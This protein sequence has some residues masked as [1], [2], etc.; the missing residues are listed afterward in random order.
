VA[1]SRHDMYIAVVL[2]AL[3]CQLTLAPHSAHAHEDDAGGLC[4]VNTTD[5]AT[6][7]VPD[8]FRNRT[9]GW[10]TE[11]FN[12][13]NFGLSAHLPVLEQIDEFAF[14]LTVPHAMDTDHHIEVMFVTDEW[15]QVVASKELDFTVD[16]KATFEFD[17][18][19]SS[20]AQGKWFHDLVYR[21]G[22]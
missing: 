16:N 22:R 6:P 10:Y 7:T 9:V 19:D 15:G 1:E 17:I 5:L 4:L 18:R 3:V 14:R 8:E 2:V 11:Q 21:D 12:P 20:L 13:L